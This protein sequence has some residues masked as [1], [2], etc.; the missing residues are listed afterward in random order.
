MKISAAVKEAFRVYFDHF[1]ASL[2]FLIVEA[3]FTLAACAPLLF[4]AEDGLK[5]LALLAVPIYLLLVLW[6]RVNAAGAMRDALNGGSLFSQRLAEPEG[7]GRKLLYGLKRLLML[8]CWSA[9]L[10][11]YV[12]FALNSFGGK[13]NVFTVFRVVKDFGGGNVT[14]GVL[15]LILILVG[16]LILIAVGCAFHCGDRHAFVRDNRK[17]LKGH[18]GGIM[19]CWVC[20]LVTLLPLIAAIIVIVFR[21]L[22]VLE[23]M[24][25]DVPLTNLTDRVPSTKTTVMIL[26]IGA[27][28][29]VP[30]LPL[31]SLIPAAYVNGLEKE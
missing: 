27:V 31:R 30:L 12:A 6:A 8:L 21:Y 14:N 24:M 17:L 29:S 18:H 2:K 28:L 10:I 9:P 19:L 1:G 5:P 4:L 16:T 7:Y 22:P 3:C 23:D 15:Y 13:E 20:S 25:G 11:A 26:A